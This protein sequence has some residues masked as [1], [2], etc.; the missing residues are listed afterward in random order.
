MPVLDETVLTIGP[1]LVQTSWLALLAGGLV[2]WSLYRWVYARSVGVP[3]RVVGDL[4]TSTLLA[5]LVAWKLS[6]VLF[7]PN[8]LR[9]PA[10]LLILSGG[11]RGV[12]VGG[13]AAALVAWRQCRKHRLSLVAALTAAL[14][15]ALPALTLY[16]LLLTRYGAPTTLP[17]GISVD[18]GERAYHPVHL[19]RAAVFAAAW[20]LL[21]R[22]RTRMSAW[23]TVRD[24][25]LL[26]IVGLFAVS[27]FEPVLAPVYGLSGTQ[28]TLL[29]AGLIIATSEVWHAYAARRAENHRHSL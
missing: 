3:P 2:G 19:Y 14:S 23:P 16:S 1:F 28:W 26:V 9:A 24:A 15:L 18:G 20:L 11:D 4:L 12:W 17:W 25:A 8:V 6:P 10:A 22:R 27:I 7:D 29:A 21:H 13:I 5:Y